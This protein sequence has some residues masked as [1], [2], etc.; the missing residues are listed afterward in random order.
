MQEDYTL[1]PLGDSALVIQ[2]V[3]RI[4]DAVHARV[5]QLFQQLQPAPSFI[6]DVVPAYA[7]LTVHYDMAAVSQN[8]KPAYAEITSFLQTILQSNPEAVAIAERIVRIPVCYAERFAPDLQELAT[9]KNLSVELVIQLHTA[10][11][12][13]VYMLGFLPGFPYMGKVDNRI[14]TPRKSSPRQSIA[15]GSVGIAGEQTGIYPLTSPGGWNII[16]R[17]P[18]PLFTKESETPVLLQPG[19]RVQFFAITEDAFENYQSRTA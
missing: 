17:T 7:S 16:G 14:A 11:V 19:D 3:N 15:A 18:L 8:G 2:F 10:V 1:A 6:K 4:D 12:Y 9:Q 5:M 13:R